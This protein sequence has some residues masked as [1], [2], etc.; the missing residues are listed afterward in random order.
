MKPIVIRY[1]LIA[2]IIVS[3][4]SSD[5]DMEP[6]EDFVAEIPS[7]F[8]ETTE[9]MEVFTTGELS[10][11]IGSE[12]FT[13]DLKSVIYTDLQSVPGLTYTMVSLVGIVLKPDRNEMIF[14]SHTSFSN[15]IIAGVTYGNSSEETFVGIL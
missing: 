6:E 3:G 1:F 2:A 4:C 11:T 8:L 15:D 12:P 14:I 10:G 5:D 7:E 13:A 9:G